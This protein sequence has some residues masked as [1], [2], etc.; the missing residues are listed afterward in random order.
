MQLDVAPKDYVPVDA[1]TKC[2]STV[3]LLVLV[4][5]GCLIALYLFV[6]L[7]E[8]LTCPTNELKHADP[9]EGTRLISWVNKAFGNHGEFLKVNCTPPSGTVFPIGQTNVTCH[10][11]DQKGHQ[12]NCT[13]KVDVVGKCDT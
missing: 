4:T 10:A 6:T 8:E 1:H 13:F 5:S 7:F 12:K 3:Y 11:E 9:Q 2:F